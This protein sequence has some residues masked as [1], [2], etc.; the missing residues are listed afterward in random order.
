MLGDVMDDSPKVRLRSLRDRLAAAAPRARLRSDAPPELVKGLSTAARQIEALMRV[1]VAAE[2]PADFADTLEDAV[3][4]ANLALHQF[5]RLVETAPQAKPKLHAGGIERRQ[6]ERLDANIT[7]KLLRHSLREDDIGGVSLKSETTSRPARNVST[8][9]IF[10]AVPRAEL[11]QVGVGNVVHVQ[12]AGGGGALVFNARAV[13]ARRDEQ[14]MGL[15]WI[16]D[17][18]RVRRDVTALLEAV[19]RG[20]TPASGRSG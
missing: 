8:G 16:L 15:S 7:V 5:D 17:G 9:G 3:A 14:G 6:H 11:A 1:A 12:I 10:V 18:D 20:A 4:E 2:L 19:R 13:V